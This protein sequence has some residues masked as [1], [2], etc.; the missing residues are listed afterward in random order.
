MNEQIRK[1]N[2]DDLADDEFEDGGVG[3]GLN[4]A[5]QSFKLLE[6][7]VEEFK[8]VK[9]ALVVHVIGQSA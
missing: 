6:H 1:D 7:P 3:G 9:E 2:L 5:T 4:A 8:A